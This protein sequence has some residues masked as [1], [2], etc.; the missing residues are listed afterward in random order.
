MIPCASK[1]SWQMDS[2]L[3]YKCVILKSDKLHLQCA[4]YLDPNN[5][6]YLFTEHL[7]ILMQVNLVDQYNRCDTIENTTHKNASS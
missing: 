5:N 6:T 3:N 7:C 4:D 2:T 1:S